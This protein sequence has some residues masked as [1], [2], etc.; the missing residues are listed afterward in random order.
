MTDQSSRTPEDAEFDAREFMHVKAWFVS[1]VY[2]DEV[3]LRKLK[4]EDIAETFKTVE[5]EAV[6]LAKRGNFQPLI[7]L[8][9]ADGPFSWL[10]PPPRQQLSAEA[11]DV[12]VLK[13]EG[14]KFEKRG[15]RPKSIQE[16]LREYPIHRPAMNVP[17]MEFLIETYRGGNPNEIEKEKIHATACDYAARIFGCK[18]LTGEMVMKYCSRSRNDRHRIPGHGE[19][20]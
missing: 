17:M 20:S 2:S 4:P 7:S 6:N 3:P 13:L 18:K 8:L 5:D 10:E 15:P 12:I 1:G 19:L 16:K 9:R 11:W 14:K